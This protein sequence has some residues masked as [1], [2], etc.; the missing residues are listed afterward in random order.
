MEGNERTN[1]LIQ[2]QI[3]DPVEDEHSPHGKYLRCEKES[4]A[5]GGHTQVAQKDGEQF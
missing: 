5:R 4:E 3:G 1:P 2:P